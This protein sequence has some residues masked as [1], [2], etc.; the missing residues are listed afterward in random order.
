MARLFRNLF[1]NKFSPPQK[2]AVVGI[3]WNIDSDWSGTLSGDI[4]L[5]AHRWYDIQ[6]EMVEGVATI[7]GSA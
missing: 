2:V 3:S 1:R 5:E 4:S 7:L 6:M